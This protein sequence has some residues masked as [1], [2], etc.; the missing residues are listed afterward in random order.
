M[1]HWDLLLSI[2][3]ANM[4]VRLPPWCAVSWI[5]LISGPL[6]GTK[7]AAG[8]RPMKDEQASR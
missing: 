5:H 7:E 1:F 6:F 3:T 8:N 4:F 2:S